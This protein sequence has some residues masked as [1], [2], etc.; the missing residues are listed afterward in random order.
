LYSFVDQPA[1]RLVTGSHFILW[2]MRGWV[3][4][5]R[6]NRCPLVTL[7]PAFSRVN[8]LE[9]LRDFHELMLDFHRGSCRCGA[10]DTLHAPRVT[11]T[12]AVMLALWSDVVAGRQ[13]R[14]NAVLALM[15]PKSPAG[16]LHRRMDRVA[17]RMAAM[18]IAPAGLA[19]LDQAASNSVPRT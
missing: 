14:A 5:A 3:V 8:V 12:E 6:Q 19:A 2:A 7:A 1:D 13:E 4:S 15:V 11:E 16:R 17:A 10:F 18:S 9:V